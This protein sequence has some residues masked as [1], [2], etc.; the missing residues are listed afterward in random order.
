MEKETPLL[1]I[2]L[3][4]LNNYGIIFLQNHT[5]KE[6]Y[7]RVNNKFY[8]DD[9]DDLYEKNFIK[10][11]KSRKMKNTY[12]GK[13]SGASKAKAINRRQR[14]TA[15]AESACFEK[16]GQTIGERR[17]KKHKNEI[18]AARKAQFLED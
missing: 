18:K 11:P 15:E 9:D 4:F 1:N 5:R 3:L 12:D 13:R 7:F 10:T 16:Y 2:L 8:Y 14:Q 6:S 17:E